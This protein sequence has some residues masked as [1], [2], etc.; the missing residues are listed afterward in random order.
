MKVSTLVSSWS[1]IRPTPSSVK[2]YQLSLK[3]FHVLFFEWP[4]INNNVLHPLM[5]WNANNASDDPI[6]GG[7]KYTWPIYMYRRF[8]EIPVNCQKFWQRARGKWATNS[9]KTSVSLHHTTTSSAWLFTAWISLVSASSWLIR[10]PSIAVSGLEEEPLVILCTCLRKQF[11][12]HLVLQKVP[13]SHSNGFPWLF[14]WLPLVIQM[15][16]RTIRIVSHRHS[17]GFL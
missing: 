10:K 7:L 11:L 13:S 14:N 12:Y 17:G 9:N 6:A 4:A 16:S 8:L 15:A 5:A 3:S 2:S 1:L